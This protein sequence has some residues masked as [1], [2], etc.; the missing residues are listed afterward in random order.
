MRGMGDFRSVFR[1]SV[2]VAVWW[3]R[4]QCGE[5]TNIFLG[6]GIV[7]CACMVVFKVKNRQSVMMNSRRCFLFEVVFEG[8][9][10]AFFR[11]GFCVGMAYY[12]VSGAI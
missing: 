7:F 11:A 9:S 8:F 12:R 2:E 10:M 5:G 3:V 1:V 6:A 4:V